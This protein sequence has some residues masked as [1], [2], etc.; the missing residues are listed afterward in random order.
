[1][2]EASTQ[3]WYGLACLGNPDLATEAL[4]EDDRMRQRVGTAAIQAARVHRG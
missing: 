1:M 2:R 3:L 4:E